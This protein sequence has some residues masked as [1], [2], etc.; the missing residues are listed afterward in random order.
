MV[1]LFIRDMG[2]VEWH[3][4]MCG[5]RVDE[6]ILA[7]RRER[8][9]PGSARGAFCHSRLMAGHDHTESLL[10]TFPRRKWGSSL[11][12]VVITAGAVRLDG[13]SLQ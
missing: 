6:V 12:D 7:H 5:E 8:E 11:G 3:C 10:R 13:A 4:V 2:S 9:A 1:Q